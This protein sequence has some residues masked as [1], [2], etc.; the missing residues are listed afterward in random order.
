MLIEKKPT[1]IA[2]LD[3]LSNNQ[4]QYQE[5]IRQVLLFEQA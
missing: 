2:K 1:M 5:F 3:A 4:M